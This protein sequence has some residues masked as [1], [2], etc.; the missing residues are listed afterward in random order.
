MNGGKHAVTPK[1]PKAGAGQGKP[2]NADEAILKIIKKRFV[3]VKESGTA[4]DAFMAHFLGSEFTL[5]ALIPYSQRPTRKKAVDN[6]RVPADAPA[7]RLKMPE[8][9]FILA[10]QCLILTFYILQEHRRRL[11]PRNK[12]RFNTSQ[13]QHC[14]FG[15][16]S[17]LHDLGDEMAAQGMFTRTWCPALYERAESDLAALARW[18]DENAPKGG[19]WPDLDFCSSRMVWRPELVGVVKGSAFTESGK[20]SK[21]GEDVEDDCWVNCGDEKTALLA[22]LPPVTRDIILRSGIPGSAVSSVHDGI[23]RTARNHL[24]MSSNEVGF[25][26]HAS[27]IRSEGVGDSRG[28]GRCRHAHACCGSEDDRGRRCGAAIRYSASR[29]PERPEGRWL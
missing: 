23:L 18:K 10:Q 15:D 9:T 17:L 11:D 16:A 5:P 14:P 6:S 26:T 12:R 1:K 3:Q 19:Y 2:K 25:E 22:A 8:E 21:V 28:R 27:R 4:G 24:A 7:Q 20:D 13:W 29:R